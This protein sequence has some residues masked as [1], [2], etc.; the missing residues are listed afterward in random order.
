[1][2][3]ERLELADDLG[4]RQI[5]EAVSE[6]AQ[7]GGEVRHQEIL[8]RPKNPHATVATLPFATAAAGLYGLLWPLVS[9]GMSRITTRVPLWGSVTSCCRRSARTARDARPR[10]QS[11][12]ARLALSPRPHQS[13]APRRWTA[14]SHA[15]AVIRAPPRRR[16]H[17]PRPARARA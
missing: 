10:A 12:P 15:A 4:R 13:A 14:W 2:C 17:R 5:V 16:H 3:A 6:G 1:L 9:V 11:A 7:L 8:V